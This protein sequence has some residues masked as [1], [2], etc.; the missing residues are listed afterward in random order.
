LANGILVSARPDGE[1]RQF[2]RTL[3]AIGS[4]S[5]KPTFIAHA[6]FVPPTAP[7]S[8]VVSR[9]PSSSGVWM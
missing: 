4:F 8:S 3:V 2:D 7:A 9:S 5:T 6:S 1:I